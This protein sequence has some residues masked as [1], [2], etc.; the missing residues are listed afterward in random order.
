[1]NSK[2]DRDGAIDDMLRATLRA[3]AARATVSDECIDAETIAAWSD[4]ALPAA[5]ATRIETHLSQCSHCQALLAALVRSAPPTT[6]PSRSIWQ[7]WQLRWVVPIA[8]AASA[9][10][11]W[12]AIP[13]DR[14]EPAP[15]ITVLDD[16]RQQ[17]APSSSAPPSNEPGQ[18]RED[19]PRNLEKRSAQREFRDA[20]EDKPASPAADSAA[21]AA[22]PER[23]DRAAASEQPQEANTLSRPAPAAPPPPNATPDQ[24][25]QR[26]ELAAL[27]ARTAD[28]AIRW[29]V[30]NRTRIERSTDAG[31]SWQAVVFP[32]ATDL[33]AIRA[34]SA[35]S[36][37]VTTVD[38]RQFRTDD[39]GKTWKA[40]TP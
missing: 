3:D 6:A 35:T 2:N 20:A 15:Q 9:L 11:L 38:N 8:A 34:L 27:E 40:F 10:A 1:V 21:A 32:E 37:I 5:G 17:P 14:R 25:S 16:S 29:R 31:V 7:R 28:P 19:A 33:V 22:A 12:I 4:G 39:A 30:V 18:L 26:Q 24:A 13:S 36:A 23:R